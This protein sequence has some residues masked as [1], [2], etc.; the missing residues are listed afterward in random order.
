MDLLS[1][2]VG[3]R[4]NFDSLHD[5]ETI[6]IKSEHVKQAK[7]DN[8]PK[9]EQE[10][11]QLSDEEK[12]YK[13]KRKEIQ[14]KLIK[15]ATRVPI[16]MYLTDCREQCLKDVI[17]QL[18]PALFKKV[19]GLDVKDFNLLVS[20][21]VFNGPVMNDAVWNF[22]RYEDA[23]LSY[24]GIDKHSGENIGLWDTSLGYY[25]AMAKLLGNSQIAE[26]RADDDRPDVLYKEYAKDDEEQAQ[27]TLIIRRS[28]VQH[29]Q[30]PTA[31]TTQV[32][33]FEKIAADNQAVQQVQKEQ[34]EKKSVVLDLSAVQVG[35]TVSHKAFGNGTVI[36]LDNSH[37]KVA[38]GDMQ[39]TFLYPDAFIQGFLKI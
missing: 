30:T 29:H 34:P 28:P 10:K 5:I 23:S 3:C 4:L 17:T 12:E 39:K 14:E 13:S 25:E 35:A 8:V 22:R 15:F 33:A 2:L 9:S 16:F 18:E 7:K 31:K 1:V 26:K 11:K 38:F 37:I 32:A 20:L 21:G 36:S 24:T 27:P 19:T 6:I